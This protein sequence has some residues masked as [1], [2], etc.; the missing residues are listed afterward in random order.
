MEYQPTINTEKIRI[1]LPS[2]NVLEDWQQI[3]WNMRSFVDRQK[4]ELK[5]IQD[6]ISDYGPYSLKKR[7]EL[8]E[9]SLN[10]LEKKVEPADQE[11][12]SISE[13]HEEEKERLREINAAIT[14]TKQEAEEVLK[15]LNKAVSG[16]KEKLG[17]FAR[18]LKR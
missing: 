5:R 17:L 4:E 7:I 18:I 12:D 10:K 9:A 6:S 1:A 13:W 15:K 11:V 2:S 3:E 16:A 14:A 8:I